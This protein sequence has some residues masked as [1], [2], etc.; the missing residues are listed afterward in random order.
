MLP[1]GAP[2]ELRPA[3]G[4]LSARRGPG[5]PWWLWGLGTLVLLVGVLSFVLPVMRARLAQGRRRSAY[6]V[7]RAELDALL[8]G[9]RPGADEVDAFFVT[10]S[11]VVRRYLEDRFGLRSPEFTT[12]E[13]LEELSRSPDLYQ[14]H[15]QLLTEFLRGADLVKFAAHVPDSAAVEA[16]IAAA[17]HFLE[18][19]REAARA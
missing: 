4:A 1:D 2:Q 13:F 6:E 14:S 9:P 16:A 5:G 17:S 8:Q 11:F 19:T 10:L 3:L 18:E 12:E 7:A 15:R